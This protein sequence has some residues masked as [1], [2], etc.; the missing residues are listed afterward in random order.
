MSELQAAV[1]LIF[2][3]SSEEFLVVRR[4]SHPGDPW[5]YQ[6][7]LPGGKRENKESL[8]ET[9]CRE[10]F[11][12]CQIVLSQPVA[13][14]QPQVAGRFT[15]YTIL[16]QPF[17]FILK[18][19]PTVILD[20]KELSGFYWVDQT[21]FQ[22]PNNHFDEK[23]SKN[24]PNLLFPTYEVEENLIWGFTYSVLVKFFN[25]NPINCL[26]SQMLKLRNLEKITK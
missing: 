19:K 21:H 3:E 18:E 8:I 15:N 16:V 22:N 9:A 1:A 24:Y 20:E 10:T 25:Q 4:S 5:S 2:V 13:S 14:L 11:E 12:E 7:A 26:E 17:L 6:M 23:M